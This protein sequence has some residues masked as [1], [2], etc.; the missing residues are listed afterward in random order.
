MKLFASLDPR[1]RRLLAFSLT[2][3]I[4]LAVVIAF[5]SRNQ[6]RDDNPMPSTYF[7][8]RHGARAGY[9]LLEASGYHV[10]RWEES[11]S[12]L[13]RQANAKSVVILADPNLTN[14][15]DFNAIE[16]ILHRGGRVLATGPEGGVLLPGNAVIPSQRFGTE[17]ELTPQGLDPLANSGQASMSMEAGWRVNDPRYRVQY[18]CA[19]APAVVEYDEGAGHV[20]WWASATPLENGSITHGDNLNLFLNGLG[21]REGHNF[22]WDE[23]LHGEARSQW[24]YASGPALDLLLGGLSAIALFVVFSFSRR[25]GPLRFLPQPARATPLEFL[26]SLGSLY[27]KA[28]AAATALNSAYDFFRRRAG[29]L[30]GRKVIGMTALELTTALRARFP[31]ASTGMDADLAACEQEIEND[32][33]EPKRALALV[34]ALNRHGAT[35]E[36]LVRGSNH[37][38]RGQ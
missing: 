22:Y 34:Q 35:L 32:R 10:Q 29:N 8:G 7:T 19:G 4:L 9:E 33:L 2:V 26:E 27:Q 38:W 13:A 16:E 25:S 21:R 14:A 31:Q 20:V 15:D 6:N 30:C 17:C 12:E 11:L 36:S 24:F 1:D 3:A 23:S 37:E 28:G 18:N 5:F